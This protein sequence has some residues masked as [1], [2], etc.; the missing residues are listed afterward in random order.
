MRLYDPCG[1]VLHTQSIGS[2]KELTTAVPDLTGMIGL[3][4]P[5]G[6]DEFSDE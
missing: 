5:V 3:I 1:R 2:L 6:A 4:G